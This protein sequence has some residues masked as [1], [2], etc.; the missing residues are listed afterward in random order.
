MGS[1]VAVSLARAGVTGFVLIDND[2]F[3]SENLVRHELDWRDI[4]MHKTD[5]LRR[6]LALVN[7]G[8][9]TKRYRIRLD[10][11]EASG[12]V[13]GALQSLSSCDVIIDATANPSVFNML[14]VVAVA[15]KRPMI[16][17]EVFA[18][19]LAE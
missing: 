1:K 19:V 5:A 17:A 4:G 7:P 12:D 11:Q 15:D 13:A 6:R 14:A 16:W 10:G 8:I 3:Y 9:S 2:I 18:G